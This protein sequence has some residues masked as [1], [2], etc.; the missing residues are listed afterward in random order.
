MICPSP[1]LLAQV[2]KV[3]MWRRRYDQ[4]VAWV[5]DSF[6]IDYIPRFVR[7]GSIFDHVFVTEQEDLGSW[8]RMVS[9]PVDWLPWG[10]DA[11]R[12]G[13]ASPAR[14]T[15]V[16][17]FGRQPPGW[18]NDDLTASACARLGLRFQGRPPPSDDPVEG[19]RALMNVLAQSKFTL[20]FSNRVSPSVQTHPER[21]YITGRW[22]EALSAGATV[23]GM[24][25]RGPS[26][27]SLLWEDA[28][29]DLGT[30]D[31]TEGLQI[32][33]RAVSRWRPRQA[34]RNYQKSLQVLDWRWRFKKLASALELQ[35]PRLDE[36]LNLLRLRIDDTAAS[37]SALAER[38]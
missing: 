28:L 5:F 25:P 2:L 37:L 6:W 10:A 11:L 14:S 22:T 18:E 27:E 21:E 34:L 32:I 4:L 20:S 13:S 17:R 23:A 1:P 30:L 36:E 33:A 9:A 31:L 26:V 8:R 15:D 19:E 29:L 12:L 16:L 35:T 38:N 3:P 7:L 24:P